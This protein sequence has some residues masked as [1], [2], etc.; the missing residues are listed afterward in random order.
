MAKFIATVAMMGVSWV[1][2]AWLLMI[3][4]GIVHLHWLTSLPTI[5]FAFSL[6]LCSLL[7]ARSFFGATMAE[8][9]KGINK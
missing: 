8:V 3:G 4:V 9:I 6:I 2:S 7:F 5:G 1:V